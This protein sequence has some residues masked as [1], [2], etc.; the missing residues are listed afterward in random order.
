V[1]V[2]D[3]SSCLSKIEGLKEPL[4]LLSPGW[5]GPLTDVDNPNG[6]RNAAAVIDPVGV[7]DRE[8][9]KELENLS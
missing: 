6:C 5:T 3:P 1:V 4:S 9:G 7:E 2:K 8:G